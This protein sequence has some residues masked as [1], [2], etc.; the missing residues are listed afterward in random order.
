MARA[1]ICDSKIPPFPARKSSD[2]LTFTHPERPVRMTSPRGR[3][4]GH[5]KRGKPQGV[6]LL[7]LATFVWGAPG[8]RPKPRTRT[9]HCLIWV[10]KGHLGL[11]FPRREHRLGI[12]DLRYIPAGT[13]FASIPMR[14]TEGY[15]AL[16]PSAL[17]QDIRAILPAD[18]IAGHIGATSPALLECLRKL[19]ACEAREI[20]APLAGLA[21]ILEGLSPLD[22]HAPSRPQQTADHPLVERFLTLARHQPLGQVSVADLARKLDSN[23]A[24][25]DRACLAARGMRAVEMLNKL[26][27][28]LAVDLL[29][30]SSQTPA[31]IAAQLGY[32]SLAHFTRSFVAATGRT[33]DAFRAQLC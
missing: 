13:A 26:R 6:S 21:K 17:I 12:G 10:T 5:G 24:T 8:P 16:I 9:E 33:P 4:G 19:A 15:V 18:G 29:R 20:F 23:V 7:P 2:S 25:L 14:D 31:G 28:E 22:R 32:S 30:Q 11:D 27:L 1:G 3:G